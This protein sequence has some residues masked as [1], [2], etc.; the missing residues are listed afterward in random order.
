MASVNVSLSGLWGTLRNRV[1]RKD[2][3]SPDVLC[4][5]M[6]SAQAQPPAGPT[7]SSCIPKQVTPP[8][9][10]A[11]SGGTTTLSHSL[12]HRT[13]FYLPRMSSFSEL[14]CGSAPRLGCPT[15]TRRTHQLP[16]ITSRT[17]SHLSYPPCIIS[18]QTVAFSWWQNVWFTSNV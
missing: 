13:H 1:V 12:Q 7:G 9:A 6:W 4:W 17:R 10:I 16:A 3:F 5:K 11:S 2:K 18:K 15:N 8:L 14:T